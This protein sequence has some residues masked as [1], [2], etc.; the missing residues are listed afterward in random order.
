[1]LN[2]SPCHSRN[3][4][5]RALPPSYLPIAISSFARAATASLGWLGVGGFERKRGFDDF[6]WAATTSLCN[7]L[8]GF[9][10]RRGFDDFSWAATA[11][12]C[13][14]PVGFEGRCGFDDFH[15]AA[16]A[17]FKVVCGGSGG[18]RGFNDFLRAAA[19]SFRRRFATRHSSVHGIL[20]RRNLAASLS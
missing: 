3:P 14:G 7:G 17:W 11:S 16:T 13:N 6:P 1:M 12:L 18:R 4:S 2:W 9:E 20:S 15:R 8:V 19:T 5:P 10:G